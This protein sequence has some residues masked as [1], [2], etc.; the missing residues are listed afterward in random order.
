MDNNICE[1]C[2]KTFSN[3]GNCQRHLTV[4]KVKKLVDEQNITKNTQEIKEIMLEKD[5]QISILT[6]EINLLKGIIENQK[7]TVINNNTNYKN[8]NNTINYISNLEPINFEEMKEKFDNNLSNKY[9]DK[10]VEGIAMFICDVPCENKF[11]TSD[12][13][14]KLVTYKNP[15]QQTIIDPKGSMLLNTAIKQNADT[16]IDKAENRYQYWKTQ[17]DEARDEDIEPDM[18]DIEKKIKTKKL[19]TIAQK[20]KQDITFDSMEA[21]NVLITKGMENKILV[22]MIDEK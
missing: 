7:P 18:S 5:R 2:K 20:A 15:Q 14:R 19:K 4:C 11:I 12:Y 3:K 16:I 21:T 13:S 10:G 22:N 1:F 6:A 17:I 9:I 8:T